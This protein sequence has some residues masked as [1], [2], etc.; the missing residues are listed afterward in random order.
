MA[1]N[2][3]FH[4]AVFGIDGEL[5]SEGNWSL[6][7]LSPNWLEFAR[8]FLEEGG[9][10][11]RKPIDGSRLSHIELQFTSDNGHALGSFYAYGQLVAST[12]YFSGANPSGETFLRGM[13]IQSLRRV[14]LVRQAAAS[15]EPFSLIESMASRPLHVVVPWGLVSIPEED[16]RAVSE[17]SNHFAGAY[18]YRRN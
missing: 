11:F 3:S 1:I 17:L 12:A 2:E 13:F 9:E 7:Q 15:P 10:V 18:F 6:A 8:T 14:E 16:H 5:A 4:V